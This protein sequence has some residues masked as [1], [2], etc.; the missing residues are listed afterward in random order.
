MPP[1]EAALRG[2]QGDRLHRGLDQRVAGG[3]VHPD[4]ADG[5]HRRPPV[6]RV[7][8]D[9]VG[10]HLRVA[11]RFA[12]DD[13][14]DVR[15]ICCRR[16]TR[17]RHG[18]LYRASERAF[19]W[20]LRALRAVARLGAPAPARSTLLVTLRDDGAQ[21]SISTCSSRRAS[22][23]QQDT[24]RL[25]GT[26]QADQD[27]S[28]QAMQRQA[29]R[30]SSTS[31]SSDPGGR[32]RDRL[33]VAAAAAPRTP[34]R[35]FV[36]LKPLGE[37]KL[38]AD[39]V[40]ARLRGKLARVPGADA[41]P[42]GR[43]RTC[44]SAAARATRSISTRCRAT[45]STELNDWAPQRAAASCARC[46][47]S[48]TS[49]AISRH[50]G[51]RR[52]WSIDRAHRVAARASRR[53]LI[54]DTLYD[55]FG[56]RQVSTMY[57]P[58]NQYHVV[59]GGRAAVLAEPGRPA[60]HLRARRRP[61]SQVPLSAFTHYAPVDDAAGRQPP[62]P[63]PGGDALVQPARPG[64]ALGDAVDGDRATPSARSACRRRSAAASRG[65]RRPSRRR[66]PASRS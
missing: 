24:G 47:S 21:R 46:R 54:D 45:T 18:R 33:H 34:A 16:T 8:G 44:A 40:I 10:R 3:G 48:P 2:R 11:G 19:D 20:I 6:P 64:V 52:R 36:A 57:T 14:D 39:Q 56:Q 23:P 51:C 15:A 25:T 32:D 63:V 58:L 28:F 35:M 55:A 49:T 12:D 4:P 17:E 31:C 66:S 59:H 9:A 50:A 5:R 53:R 1:L 41:V 37:R 29:A 62:G 27:T 38:S 30:S 42:A 60:V 26:I 43:C 7:R 61:A 13:A 22:F 65:R